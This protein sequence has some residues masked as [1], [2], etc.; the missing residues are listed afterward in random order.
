MY[1]TPAIRP[2]T[3][4]GRSLAH[5]AQSRSTLADQGGLFRAR[6]Y[7]FL[8]LD[9]VA[10]LRLGQLEE[11][12]DE[13]IAPVQTERCRDTADGQRNGARKQVMASQSCDRPA[14]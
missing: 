1:D 7:F 13:R 6:R 5:T 4:L 12:F 11:G 8:R 14:Q 3:N 10:A 2:P 9:F